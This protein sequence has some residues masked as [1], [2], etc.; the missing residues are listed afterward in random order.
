[1]GIGGLQKFSLIDYPEKICAIV[2]TQGCNFRC[3]Y[4]FTEDTLVL[5]DRGLLKIGDIVEKNIKCKV[6]DYEGNF[7]SIKRYYKREASSL[8]KIKPF[9][10]SNELNCTPNHKFFVYNKK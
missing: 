6:Y 8:L 2:F 4:C 5:T 1:M 10:N 7:S 3:P 9:L